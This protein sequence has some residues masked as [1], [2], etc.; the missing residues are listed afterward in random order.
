MVVDVDRGKTG[1][2]R[3]PGARSRSPAACRSTSRTMRPCASAM[4]PSIK[5]CSFKVE[6][7]CVARLEGANNDLGPAD[8]HHA[9]STV[10]QIKYN[11][12]HLTAHGSAVPTRTPTGC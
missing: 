8:T 11:L 9:R 4:K 2:G 5:R 7:R 10:R 1:G 12:L 6:A 3:T